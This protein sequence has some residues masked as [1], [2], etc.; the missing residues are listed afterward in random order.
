[1]SEADAPPLAARTRRALRRPGPVAAMLL[2]VAFQALCL[3]V[4][5]FSTLGPVLG[6]RSRPIGWQ[7]LELIQ[8]AAL[9]GLAAGLVLGARGF[10]RSLRN[11][12]AAEAEL[13]RVTAT[14]R[15]MLA[16]HFA[17]WGLTPAERDVALLAI[18]GLSLQEI[19][20][21]RNTSEGTVRAQTAA[22]YRKAGVS[23]RPQL[24]ALFIEDM[25]REDAPLP[26]AGPASLPVAARAP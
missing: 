21:L 15:D 5:A 1:M 26:D 24:L 19:A 14:F 25:M 20:R 23:G 7:W 18:K 8:I 17:D 16:R 12:R 10:L 2:L 13:R 6:L 3:A 9:L 11:G 22:I 4:F